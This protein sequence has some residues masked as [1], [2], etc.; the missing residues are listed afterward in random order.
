MELFEADETGFKDLPFKA[1]R[2]TTG[3]VLRISFGCSFWG[4]KGK[5]KGHILG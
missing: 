2:D 5:P 1:R 3:R 4:G